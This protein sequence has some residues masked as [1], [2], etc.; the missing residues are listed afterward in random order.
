MLTIN[1]LLSLASFL[2]YYISCPKKMLPNQFILAYSGSPFCPFG[3]A[4]EESHSKSMCLALACRCWLFQLFSPLF[5]KPILLVRLSWN[6]SLDLD[7]TAKR[8][9]LWNSSVAHVQ[10]WKKHFCSVSI[11]EK[12][13]LVLSKGGPL[14]QGL[15]VQ[16]IWKSICFRGNHLY[17]TIHVSGGQ[18]ISLLRP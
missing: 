2:A 18:V 11:Q 9:G 6:L 16:V 1:L 4:P 17:I 3:Q 7:L 5:V 15:R 10:L 13:H 8:V 12:F 14:L